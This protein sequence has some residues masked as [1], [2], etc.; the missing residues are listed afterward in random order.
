MKNYALQIV[1]GAV[2]GC[3]LLA[4][5]CST[6]ERRDWTILQTD[7]YGNTFSYDAASVQHLPAGTVTVRAKSLSA[8]YLYEMDCANNRARLLQEPGASPQ[9]FAVVSGSAEAL[10]YRAVCP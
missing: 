1:T 7:A 8:E 10:L 3:A 4:W 9:W 6:A 2:C 5:G